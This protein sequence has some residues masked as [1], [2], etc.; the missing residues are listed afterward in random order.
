MS[1]FHANTILN[2]QVRVSSDSCQFAICRTCMD[3]F[4]E[5]AVRRQRSWAAQCLWLVLWVG[6]G[7]PD[8]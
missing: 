7:M 1:E 4:G 3:Q 5:L 2:R 6:M 8:H